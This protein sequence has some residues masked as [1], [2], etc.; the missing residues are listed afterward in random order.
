MQSARRTAVLV[1][2]PMPV[3]V[4]DAVNVEPMP[5]GPKGVDAAADPA[6]RT[7]VPKLGMQRERREFHR[8]R[9]SEDTGRATPRNGSAVGSGDRVDEIQRG[10]SAVHPDLP[11][12]VRERFAEQPDVG[13]VD[14]VSTGAVVR[15]VERAERVLVQE[16]GEPLDERCEN[17]GVLSESEL[18]ASEFASRQHRRV[19]A[20]KDVGVEEFDPIPTVGGALDLGALCLGRVDEQWVVGELPAPKQGL[21]DAVREEGVRGAAVDLGEEPGD[22]IV[23]RFVGDVSDAALRKV[24][25]REHEVGPHVRVHPVAGEGSRNPPVRKVGGGEL[26]H[27]GGDEAQ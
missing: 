6:A 25:E 27:G 21:G 3:R 20:R 22:D 7:V 12:P 17:G 9:S 16:G 11:E 1:L 4:D 19:V 14:V 13:R 2:V 26:R 8:E 10:A 15:V 23:D 18:G 24:R 5:S